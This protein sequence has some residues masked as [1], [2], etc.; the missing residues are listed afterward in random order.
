MAE[1]TMKADLMP[2]KRFLDSL[3]ELTSKH[4]TEHVDIQKEARRGC[5]F[6]LRVI[7]R[8]SAGRNDT[9]NMGMVEQVLSPR[10]QHAE[11][12]NLRTQVVGIG[13]NLEHRVSAD[14]KKQ[15]IEKA[16]VL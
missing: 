5:A 11:K 16:F 6:P 14:A 10:M 1:L 9:M 12:T 7:L 3:L 4:S 13:G 2:L 8:Q 15:L